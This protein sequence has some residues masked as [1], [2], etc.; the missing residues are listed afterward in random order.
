MSQVI[1]TEPPATTRPATEHTFRT[2]DGVDLFYRAWVPASESHRAVVLFHRGH[3]HSARWQDFIDRIRL[4][5]FWFFG[6]DARGHGRSPGDRG[7]AESFGRM[8]RD[9]EEF[10]RHLSQQFD[11]PIENMAV[12][13]Q[14]VGAVL[15]A[16]WVHDYAPPIR[17]L[18][19]ATPA[20]RVKLYMP[21]AIPSL[22]IWSKFRPKSFIRSYVKPKMLTHDREQAREYANDPIIS[23]Q[24]AVNILLD[25][26]DTS[27]RLVRDAGAITTPTLVL[28]SGR[29]WVVEKVPQ[30]RLYTR[31]SSEVKDKVVYPEFYH[32]TFWEQNRQLPIDRTRQFIQAA[33]EAP[34]A[35]ASLV[36]ADKTG[37]TKRVYDRL[38]CPLPATSLKWW[39]FAVQRL[40]LQTVGR[41]SKGVS[42]GWQTGFD[43]GESLDHVYRNTPE[44]K[45]F[46]G[47]WIDRFYLDTPGWRGIRQRKVNLQ[48]L[49][50]EAIDIL[51]GQGRPI[52]MLDI[53]AG[54]GRYVLDTI[55]KQK[56]RGIDVSATLCDRD[57]GGLAAGRKLAES[58]GITSVEYRESDAFNGDTIAAIE[59]RPTIAIVSGLY[60]LFPSNAPLR[61][62]LRGLAAAVEPG[63]VLIYTDQPWH[64][65]QEMIARVL[66]N[67]DGD[68]WVMRCRTQAEMDQLVAAA[69]FEKV[70]TLV[71]DEG[72]FSV[73]MAVK[74]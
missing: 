16:T 57:R 74:R 33:F 52:R 53:A 12:V 50:D 30:H 29:D 66:P 37:Y 41:L 71:D 11:I 46:L 18:A 55:A 6:W 34:A 36:D 49:L 19:V 4:D 3:E 58:M 13:S 48:Q 23:P 65:Q 56:E 17:A 8:V 44:G 42:T 2:S 14:S 43:S 10:V 54:P 7:Y 15:A 69:G 67:R 27:T 63:G 25:L 73:S 72:I 60:E 1:A 45:S 26:Y 35:A 64:P 38:Q 40:M 51:H 20:L 24:I 31:L 61:E 9:A 62:S 22:R 59:P 5:D 70:R 21:L 28:I 39:S 68:P 32:S 47:R